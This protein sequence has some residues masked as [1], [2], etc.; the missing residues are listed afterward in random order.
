[1]GM[2]IRFKAALLFVKDVT[3]SRRFYEG[4]LGQKVEY[5]FGEDVE[6][7]GGFAIHDANHI[8]RLLFNRNNPN[9]EGMQG[10]ENFELYFESDNIDEINSVLLQSGVT[11]V[12]SLLEQPWGQRVIR[13]YDPDGHI[14]EIGEPMSAVIKRYLKMGMTEVAVAQ[15]TSMPIE[16]VK[17]IKSEID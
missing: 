10:K 16:E 13:F 15:K 6:F 14:I 12:H 2:N 8:S 17:R 11:F 9:S 7:C 5:D 1:M 4:V 3:V